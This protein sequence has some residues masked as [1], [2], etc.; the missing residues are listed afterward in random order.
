GLASAGARGVATV[1]VNAMTVLALHVHGAVAPVGEEAAGH[2]DAHI[3]ARAFRRAAAGG[4]KASGGVL[5]T[6]GIAVVT[7]CRHGGAGAIAQRGG[8]EVAGRN[9]A[10]RRRARRPR[11]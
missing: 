7:G 4:S 3:G 2:I 5:A 11:N 10:A 8:H 6:I 9:I 1:T